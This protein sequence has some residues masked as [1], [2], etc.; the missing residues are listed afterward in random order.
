MLLPDT[1]EF[2]LTNQK[3]ELQY[4]RIQLLEQFSIFLTIFGYF[5]VILS[6]KSI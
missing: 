6:P 5:P 4:K 1:Y 3:Y 2:Y